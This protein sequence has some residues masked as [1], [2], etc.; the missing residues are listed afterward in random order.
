MQQEAIKQF[1]ALNRLYAAL[2][3]LIIVAVVVASLIVSNTGSLLSENPA[4]FT[5]LQTVAFAISA[6]LMVL[7]YAM[8]QKIVSRIPES[9][10]LDEKMIDYRK[11]ITW[12]LAFITDAALAVLVFFTLTGNTNLILVLA[13]IL[14]FHILARP[15]PF[16]TA[17]D[18]KLNEEE[19]LLLIQFNDRPIEN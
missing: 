10:P 3:A 9:D 2:F 15:T 11:A 14:I 12:R 16:K 18:L 1:R 19:K 5:H 13:M 4:L 17:S 6:I 8:P 7:A